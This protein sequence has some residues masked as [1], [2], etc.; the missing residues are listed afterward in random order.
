MGTSLSIPGGFQSGLDSSHSSSDDSVFHIGCLLDQAVTYYQSIAF[1]VL[2]YPTQYPQE[3][4]STFSIF[5]NIE[6]ILRSVFK[7]TLMLFH[8]N[9]LRP[10][11]SIGLIPS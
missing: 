8:N 4:V 6:E 11:R 2:L 3:T 5:A 7:T 10:P 1:L 9:H